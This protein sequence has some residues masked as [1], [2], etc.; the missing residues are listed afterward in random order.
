MVSFNHFIQT[1]EKRKEHDTLRCINCW[2]RQP[3]HN[4][5]NRKKNH[6]FKNRNAFFRRISWGFSN[7][8]VKW[9]KIR[10]D[11][12]ACCVSLS[13]W[14]VICVVVS[15]RFGWMSW[16]DWFERIK[17]NF[18][19]FIFFIE[20]SCIEWESWRGKNLFFIYVH[21]YSWYEWVPLL[22]LGSA[23]PKWW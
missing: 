8:K 23:Q 5:L 18:N 7:K 20:M 17:T 14:N 10:Y 3:F 15:C 19:F 16:M 2:C 12:L 21:S 1:G 9:M 13:F 11:S 6:P 4:C 22:W